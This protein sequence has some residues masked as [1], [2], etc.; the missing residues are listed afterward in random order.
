MISNRK[1]TLRRLFAVLQ[2]W[3]RN[4]DGVAAIEFAFIAPVMLIMFFGLFEMGRAYAM[5]R[6][7]IT[8]T[9]TIGDLIAR[10]E[11]VTDGDLEGIYKSVPLIMGGYDNS[12]LKVE[13]IPL[14]IPAG[15]PGEVRRYAT[16]KRRDATVPACGTY[17]ATTDEKNVLESS[18]KGAIKVVA[19]YDF[20]PIFNYP[21]IGKMTWQSEATFAP[22]QACVAFGASG[23]AKSC[24]S[25]CS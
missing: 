2:S 11:A 15:N 19:T 13:V 21:L 7:F 18:T 14:H 9:Y 1:A 23:S 22:R 3:R 24:S 25:P 5:H 10:E 8:T 16:P 4:S 6:R 17:P 12:V 20:K